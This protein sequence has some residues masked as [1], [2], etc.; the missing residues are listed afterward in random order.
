MLIVIGLA[1]PRIQRVDLGRLPEDIVIERENFRLY[2]PITTSIL[3][4]VLLT[5]IFWFMRK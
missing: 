5:S 4:S 3:I 2:L 1:W